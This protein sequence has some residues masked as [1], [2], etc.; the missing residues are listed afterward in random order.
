MSGLEKLM[1]A[2][3]EL[4]SLSTQISRLAVQAER[5]ATVVAEHESRLSRL[6]GK[7]EAYLTIAR[8]TGDEP[9]G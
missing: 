7:F 8:P 3:Q 6:E 9:H 5:L 4:F 2:V 1:A